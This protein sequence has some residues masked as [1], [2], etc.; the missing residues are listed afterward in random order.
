ML[1][2]AAV[3]ALTMLVVG[4]AALLPAGAS[5]TILPLLSLDETAG[6]A[7]ASVGSLGF[8]IELNQSPGDAVRDLSIVLPVG[9]AIDVDAGGGACSPPRRR[10]PRARS[11]RAPR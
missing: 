9:A 7:A 10:S 6:S 1:R 2:R 11:A 8:Q 5:A 4:G 3:L